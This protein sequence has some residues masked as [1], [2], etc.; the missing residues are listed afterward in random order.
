[1]SGGDPVQLDLVAS[2]NRPG[3]N[4]TGVTFLVATLAAKLLGLLRDLLPQ[5]AHMA[6]LTDPQ[7]ARHRVLCVGYPGCR[8]GPWKAGGSP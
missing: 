4:V 3:G 1:M 8:G 2:L 7:Y 6:V 5:A